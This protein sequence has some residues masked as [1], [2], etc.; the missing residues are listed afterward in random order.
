MIK[1]LLVDDQAHIRQGLRMRLDMEPDMVVVG[2]AAGGK[3]ALAL[4]ER[5]RPGV[6]VMDVEMAGLDGITA[7]SRLRHICPS[8]AVVILTMHGGAA[9]RQ[10]ALEAGAVAFIEK[11]ATGEELASAIRLAADG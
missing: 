11:P 7:T 10:L 1:V 4:A 8:C 5:L 9:V 6:I 3:E 2:E